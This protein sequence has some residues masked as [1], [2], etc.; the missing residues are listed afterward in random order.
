MGMFLLP[1]SI[2][3]K[4]NQL[5]RKFW[6]GYNEDTFKIQWVGSDKINTNKESGG[7][8]FRDFKRFNLALLSRQGWR[9][10]HN[11]NS[12]VS[13]ILKQRYFSQVG[14]LDSRLGPGPSFAWKGIQ[15]GLTLLRKGIVWRIGNGTKVNIW[16]DRWITGFQLGK[17]LSTRDADY[18]CEK[19]SDLIDPQQKKWKESLLLELFSHQEIEAIKAIPIS[20]GGRDDVR[21]WP[22]TNNGLFTVKSCY[23][24]G[25]DMDRHLEG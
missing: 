13:M 9:I 25:R 14:L 10:I 18:W 3:R 19:V 11:P 8:G 24:F 21:I 6:W 7:L 20:L 1:V 17:V 2:I 4:L 12:L 5:L 23:H 16:K 15:A 22:W